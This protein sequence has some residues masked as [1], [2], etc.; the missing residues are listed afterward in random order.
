MIL[1]EGG[2]IWQDRK[3]PLLAQAM[4][5]ISWR[6][7]NNFAWDHT[8]RQPFWETLCQLFPAEMLPMGTINAAVDRVF[9]YLSCKAPIE[10][11]FSGECLHCHQELGW[12]R[13]KFEQALGI[14]TCNLKNIPE[15]LAELCLAMIAKQIKRLIGPGAKRIQCFACSSWGI[16]SENLTFGNLFLPSVVILGFGIQP[17]GVQTTSCKVEEEVFL[18]DETY[19]L[20]AAVITKPSHFIGVTKLQ[21][22]FYNMDNLDQGR[23]K[24]GFSCFKAAVMNDEL[25][26]KEELILDKRSRDGRR[27]G[28]VQYT[29]Y[30]GKKGSSGKLFKMYHDV[31]VDVNRLL[32]NVPDKKPVDV[33]ERKAHEE[34]VG[35]LC[36]EFPS[37]VQGEAESHNN[38]SSN[39]SGEQI[40][41][42]DSSVESCGIIRSSE[43]NSRV[44]RVDSDIGDS[45][46]DTTAVID[47][48]Q[49][50]DEDLLETK[51]MTD[52]DSE[53]GENKFEEATAQSQD[54]GLEES[55][56]CSRLPS[57]QRLHDSKI[58]SCEKGF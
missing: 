41:G 42:V 9:D 29:V 46:E 55:N 32:E 14:S 24:Q 8:I 2:L 21:E 50:Q 53:L 30:V 7:S 56:G 17:R 35:N 52:E 37:S 28:A 16:K 1:T 45:D 48:V 38:A 49:Y 5:M 13:Y 23:G 58:I 43:G 47:D 4:D 33:T 25:G 6:L 26:H 57:E 22:K 36:S 11:V 19:E 15:S 20:T 31:S 10:V 12:F 3:D 44:K 54:E 18:G 39:S 27:A 51:D 40:G 34:K